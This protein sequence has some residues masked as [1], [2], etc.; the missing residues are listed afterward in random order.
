M[1]DFETWLSHCLDDVSDSR[2]KEAM[3]YSLM[4]GGKRI[5][6]R[7]LFATL[8]AYGCRDI[9]IGYPAAAAIEMVHTYSLIHDDLPAMDNDTL[10]R[11]VATCHVRFD[12][13]TAILAGD[14][15]LTQAFLMGVRASDDLRVVSDIIT[16]LS[17]Y[18]GADGMV[19]GQ[20]KDLEAEVNPDVS[21]AQLEDVH[22]FKTGKLLT[23]PMLFAACIL[24]H[25]EDMETWVKIGRYLGLS[26]Q[27]QDD[28]LDVTSTKEELGK[29]IN[30]DANN[31]KHTYVTLLGIEKA[32]KAADT[33]YQKAW[34]CMASLDIH[35]DCLKPLF[36]ALTKRK[37]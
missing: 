11:G 24:H 26:F 4:A 13:A 1:N 25:Q 33:Y 34:D 18:S 17:Q 19:L 16:L 7:L 30:S 8:E 36:D 2:I 28:I 14:A 31:H 22:L 10:R 3:L 35:H 27:I 32:Q 37:H 9:H 21:L 5:R 15:M 23:L 20:M 29:N 6:P 12:E